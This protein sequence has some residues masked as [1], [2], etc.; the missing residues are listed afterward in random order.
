MSK[1]SNH[2]KYDEL[3][4]DLVYRFKTIQKQHLFCLLKACKRNSKIDER[5]Q[6]LCGKNLIYKCFFKLD[7]CKNLAYYCKNKTE[8][9]KPYWMPKQNRH[10]IIVE[11]IAFY[12][13]FRGSKVKCEDYIENSKVRFDLM[14]TEPDGSIIYYEIELSKKNK[15]EIREKLN[16]YGL[17]GK[18]QSL[19]LVFGNKN[20]LENLIKNAGDFYN[21]LVYEPSLLE[22]YQLEYISV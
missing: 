12:K 4:L 17:V 18:L 5:L 11:Q 22:E 9:N 15:W 7:K 8:S 20:L 2:S 1:K 3:I 14:S 16:E 10:Q 21:Q 6:I 19:K 13:E